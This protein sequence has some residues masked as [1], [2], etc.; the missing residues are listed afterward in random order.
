MHFSCF[1]SFWS[2]TFLDQFR[3]EDFVFF[4]AP[5]IYWSS[6]C[7]KNMIQK[8][9]TQQKK[10]LTNKL[11]FGICYTRNSN[12]FSN[13]THISTNFNINI[14]MH[15]PICSP[16][17]SNIPSC[18]SINQ[19]PSSNL[20]AAFFNESVM[21]SYQNILKLILPMIDISVSTIWSLSNYSSIVILLF[22]NHNI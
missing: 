1:R 7:P 15:S 21:K 3:I 20:C 13:A 18:R 8:E 17:I 12:R 19:R 2:K 6:L 16:T 9:K 5:L 11:T 4:L 22:V 14:S 10:H